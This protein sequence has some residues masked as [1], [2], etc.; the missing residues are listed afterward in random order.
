MKLRKEITLIVLVIVVAA[1]GFSS[2]GDDNNYQKL[3]DEELA[4]LDDFVLRY[5]TEHNVDIEPTASGL[6]FIEKE[7][8]SGD[9]IFV[10]DRVQVWY[11]TYTLKDT[12]L[13]DSNMKNGKYNPLEFFAAPPSSSSVIEGLN[14]AVQK[15]MFVGSKAFLIIPSEIAYGQDGTT[16]VSPFT[17]LLMDVE[18]Y[19]VYPASEGN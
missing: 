2:C 14:E 11:N 17:T 7:K 1:L 13:V 19:K 10:G 15:N 8:G 4:L 3:R 12:V 9:T 5:E 6:Y 16:G 18:I